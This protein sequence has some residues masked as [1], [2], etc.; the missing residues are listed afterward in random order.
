MIYHQQGDCLIKP[1]EKIP[2][3]VEK[4]LQRNILI[5]GE[6]TGNAHRVTEG[7]FELFIEA[8]KIFLRAITGCK[9][10]HEEHQEI[11]IAPG[12]YEIDRVREVD[13]FE[14]AIR[15]VRD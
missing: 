5:E 12:D 7:E 10:T 14:N 1:I 4:V 3:R 15:R 8:E 2:D 11:V 6:H 13:P 9:V